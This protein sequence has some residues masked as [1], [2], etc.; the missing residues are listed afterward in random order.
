MTYVGRIPTS[1]KST[2]TISRVEEK[3]GWVMYPMLQMI[4]K[5]LCETKPYSNRIDVCLSAYLS[6]CLSH[7]FNSEK[8]N[9]IVENVS[10]VDPFT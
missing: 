1:E 3:M 6:L 7:P 10:S 4:S 5:V 8:A 2:Q 9:P